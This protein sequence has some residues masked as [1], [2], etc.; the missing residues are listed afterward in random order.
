MRAEEEGG[1]AARRL[2][3]R[4][5]AGAARLVGVL[6]LLRLG[7]EH[8][9]APLRVVPPG[10]VGAAIE[11]GYAWLAVVAAVNTVVSIVYY[12]RVLAP[13][14]FGDRVEPVSVLGRWAEVTTFAMAAA[15]ILAGIAAEPFW[16]AF[17]E[18]GLVL[19]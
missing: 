16:R 4:R 15:V 7:G 8:V 5:L 9:D 19:E 13:A 12:V 11:A 6:V 10:R 17:S 1:G 18:I 14:Y 3:A 2:A